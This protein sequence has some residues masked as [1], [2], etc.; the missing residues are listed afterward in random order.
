MKKIVHVITG[1]QQAGA[2]TLLFR[3]VSSDVEN[4]H[5][6]VSLTSMGYYGEIL[7]KA[8]FEVHEI[9]FTIGRLLG[10]SYKLFKVLSKH[11]T[12]VVHCWMYHANFI[13]GIAAKF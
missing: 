5:V 8:G 12:A 3:L 11:H 1:L 6:I 4:K 9:N 13:G 2:E 7:S 10:S